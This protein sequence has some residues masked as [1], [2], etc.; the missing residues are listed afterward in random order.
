MEPTS[1]WLLS[2]S[3]SASLN[4]VRYFILSGGAF[5]VIWVNREKLVRFRIQKTDVKQPQIIHDIKW[6]ISTAL[7]QGVLTALVLLYG[8]TRI[9]Y[10]VSDYGWAYLFLSLIPLFAFLDAY[11]YFS[12]RLLHWKPLLKRIHITHHQSKVPTAFST[13]S[14]HPLEA[15]I[16]WLVFP[17]IVYTIP[18]HYILLGVFFGFTFLINNLGH[19][20]YE[21]YPKGFTRHPIFK[22]SNTS[23]FHNMHHTYVNCNYGLYFNFLDTWFGTTHPEYEKLYDDIK[24]RS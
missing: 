3:T 12:H 13:I 10:H 20:G 6:S 21:F 15:L 18:A 9:Y 23:T 22:W 2:A 8:H 7:I 16:Q 5:L 17:L 19:L 11:F 14:F 1:N 24:N 4:V